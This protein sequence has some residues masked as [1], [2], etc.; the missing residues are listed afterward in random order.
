NRI[1]M[2][3]KRNIALVT[4]GSRGLGKNMALALAK[5]GMDVMITYHSN[6]EAADE[7]VSE[8]HS[9]GQK[10]VAFQ[11]DTGDVK[12]FDSFIKQVT[13]YLQEHTG[14]P[15]FDFLINNAGTALYALATDTTEE[16]LDTAFNIHYKG[17]FFLTQKAL[18]YINDG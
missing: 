3:T 6:K 16:Q 10:A 13:E 18:H 9:L 4:G 8:I 11:L 12:R 5:K 14:S 1:N 17:V 15:N 7:V 2:N